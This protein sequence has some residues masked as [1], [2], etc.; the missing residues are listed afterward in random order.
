MSMDIPTNVHI[1]LFDTASAF[2]PKWF[3]GVQ[4]RNIVVVFSVGCRRTFLS[5]YARELDS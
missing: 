2:R 5:V 3:V 4:A 1:A